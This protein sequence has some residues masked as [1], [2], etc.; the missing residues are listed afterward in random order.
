MVKESH[1]T[2]RFDGQSV[3]LSICLS[4]CLPVRS[5]VSQSVCLVSV[6]LQ[7]SL[8]TCPSY[9]QLFSVRP[10][11]CPFIHLSVQPSIYLSSHLSF[12][13][14]KCL[15]ACPLISPSVH[16][17]VCLT[18]KLTFVPFV[19]LSVYLV[20]IEVYYLKVTG[21]SSCLVIYYY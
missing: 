6:C 16:S 10:S 12:S 15:S 2:I 17:S 20:F 14:L 21:D 8:F 9:G 3:C 19:Q 13:L 7:S 5:S 18:I 11:V 4:S 1:S